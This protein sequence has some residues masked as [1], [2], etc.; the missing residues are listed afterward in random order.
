MTGSVEDYGEL[1][2]RASEFLHV[3]ADPAEPAQPSPVE[4]ITTASGLR[5]RAGEFTP[6]AEPEPVLDRG[7]LLTRAR[8]FLVAPEPPADVDAG[9]VIAAEGR[10][11]ADAEPFLAERLPVLPEHDTAVVADDDDVAGEGDTGADNEPTE[12]EQ[13]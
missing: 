1:L 6:H 7:E 13:P 10:V 3:P 4:A 9:A 12:V 11:R 2:A 8:E 5:A